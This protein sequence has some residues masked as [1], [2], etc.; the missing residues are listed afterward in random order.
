[1][2]DTL[3]RLPLQ[4]GIDNGGEAHTHCSD[5][6]D[7]LSLLNILLVRTLI[8]LTQ[9]ANVQD[10]LDSPN[11]AY[12]KPQQPERQE[13]NGC[14]RHNAQPVDRGGTGVPNDI[15]TNTE[16]WLNW[17]ATF[18]P[19]AENFIRQCPIRRYPAGSPALTASTWPEMFLARSLARNRVA[20]AMSSAVVMRRSGERSS[21]A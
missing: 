9:M 18:D 3:R 1:L 12:M 14:W 7:A 11:I 15:L 16:H 8:F 2:R 10:R 21:V 13:R 17:P 4:E 19:L 20:S 6:I 5:P